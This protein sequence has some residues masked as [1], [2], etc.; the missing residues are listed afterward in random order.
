MKDDGESLIVRCIVG[1]TKPKELRASRAG[2]SSETLVLGDHKGEII[3]AATRNSVG[4][5]DNSLGDILTC[6]GTGLTKAA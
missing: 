5:D 1:R 2:A 6:F 4:D 3:S